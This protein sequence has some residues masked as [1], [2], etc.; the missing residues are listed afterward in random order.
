MFFCWL[1]L[2]GVALM[3][4]GHGLQAERTALIDSDTP[5]FDDPISSFFDNAWHAE[6]GSFTPSYILWEDRYNY[7]DVSHDE[8]TGIAIGPEG[9]IWVTGMI[10]NPDT[11]FDFY[12]IIYDPDG[13]ILN[14]MSYDGDSH[15][16]DIP[17]DL[18]VDH[19]S[20]CY[21][22]G[23]TWDSSSEEDIVLLKYDPAGTLLWEDYYDGSA[24]E[25]DTPSEIALD[26]SGRIGV[27]GTSD[28][29][30]FGGLKDYV[31]IIWD[32]NGDVLCEQIYS[33]PFFLGDFGLSITFDSQGNCIVTGNSLQGFSQYDIATIKY[34]TDCSTLWEA[35][36]NGPIDEG[37]YAAKVRVDSQD[38]VIVAGYSRSGT[39]HRDYLILKYN[40]DGELIW[41]KRYNGPRYHEDYSAD[42]VL[43]E[44][45]N[46]Y[47]T[48]KSRGS[49]FDYDIA[50][51]KYSADGNRE[52]AQRYNGV[53]KW[54]D[55]GHA[56][57]LD[58][59]GN[60][61]VTGTTYDVF[62]GGTD[63]ITIKYDSDGTSLWVRRSD[64]QSQ[65]D[66]RPAGIVIDDNEGLYMT[67]T[68]FDDPDTGFD[69]Y[70]VK[71]SP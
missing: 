58:G 37:D 18:I 66:D 52:W 21:V 67:G 60:V 24:H 49:T 36:F 3:H 56:I 25:A 57:T 44:N 16:D 41:Q 55:E 63:I 61:Y 33:G 7:D 4:A 38:Q 32:S 31:T 64:G 65:G 68:V 5:G 40:T 69:Y 43:D 28:N 54:D 27:V 35:V 39:S 30:L 42:M 70:T 62:E 47:V 19:D 23:Q 26:P 22:V 1:L 48:G 6:P 17:R 2:A 29:G 50:T 15:G 8:P 11:G 13:N 46:I 9:N 34:D 14:V 51:V 10:E 53:G 71:Q 20:N 59:S 45:D 12:T